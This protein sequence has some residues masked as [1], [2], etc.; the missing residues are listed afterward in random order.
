MYM[1]HQELTSV[2]I[3]VSYTMDMTHYSVKTGLES[4]RFA[5]WH[6]QRPIKVRFTYT[7]QMVSMKMPWLSAWL[8]VN[9]RRHA[10]SKGTK[11]WSQREIGTR[12][13]SPV[14]HHP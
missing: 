3:D 5:N 8:L 11:M 7:L 10:G 9:I 6:N 1:N 12:H 4:E 2:A 14:Y 13:M